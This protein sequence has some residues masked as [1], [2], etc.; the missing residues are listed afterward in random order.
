MKAATEFMEDAR[1][2]KAM[3]DGDQVGEV[4]HSL[5]LTKE[6]GES[7]GVQSD[8]EGW[9][10]A[11]RI[12]DDEVWK[13]VKSGELKA[14][15]IGGSGVRQTLRRRAELQSQ[16][17]EIAEAIQVRRVEGEHRF[18]SSTRPRPGPC[19]TSVPMKK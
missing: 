6:L 13:R 12:H 14:F 18:G 10:V 1:I 7:L 4:I 11:M 3:H 2:A 16:A 19:R 8:R 9:I 15:S 5:P 17:R